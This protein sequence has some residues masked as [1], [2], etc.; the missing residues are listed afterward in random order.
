[1]EKILVADL[2]VVN[3][4]NMDYNSFCLRRK[5][6][7]QSIN[8]ERRKEQSYFV[9]AL[10]LHGLKK[11]FDLS[12][13]VEFQCDLNGR[14]KLLNKNIWFSLS[15]SNNLVCVFIS[16]E[17]D[18]CIDVEMC[19][20][21]ILKISNKFCCHQSFTNEEGTI[22]SLTKLWTRFECEKKLNSCGISNSITLYDKEKNNYI[23]S[24]GTKKIKEDNYVEIICENIINLM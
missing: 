17:S 20:D 13:D 8:N 16:D 2:L 14:W 18:V 22:E 12:N 7:I 24:Y 6:Y 15:H 23:L 9:W 3:K 5:E 10:L 4:N 1:M 21:K 19:S 11:Y